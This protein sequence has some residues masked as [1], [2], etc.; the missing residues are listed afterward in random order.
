[1]MKTRLHTLPLV[2][3]VIMLRIIRIK[4]SFH[5][6][7]I[8]FANKTYPQVVEEITASNKANKMKVVLC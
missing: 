8:S 2:V 1:M 4:R 3:E 7:F 5:W 6:S